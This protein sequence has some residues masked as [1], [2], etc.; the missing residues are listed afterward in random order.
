MI[1][2]I[3]PTEFFLLSQESGALVLIDVRESDEV[4]EVAIPVA[5]NCP[6][7][8]FDADAIATCYGKQESL[9]LI[10]RSGRRSLKAAL[11]LEAVGFS[12][13]YNVEGGVLEWLGH[14]LP[15]VRQ[16]R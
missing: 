7:S 8:R 1:K 2:S 6:L 12:S 4:R 5:T 10:C 13:L 11:L 16:P 14:G 9:Y 15:T 3:R